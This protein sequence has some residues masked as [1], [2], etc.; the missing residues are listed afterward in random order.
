MSIPDTTIERLVFVRYV[1]RMGVEQ[2][3][4]QEP[5][6]A[7]AILLFHDSADLFLQ[8]AAEHLGASLPV[9]RKKLFIMDFFGAVDALLAK[10]NQRLSERLGI[11]RLTGARNELKHRGLRTAPQDVEGLRASLTNFFAENVPVTF[12]INFD[13]ITMARAVG[14]PEVREQLESAER[15]TAGGDFEGA[16]ERCAVAFAYLMLAYRDVEPEV[17][18]DPLRAG[19]FRWKHPE[20]IEELARWVGELS[21]TIQSLEQRILPLSLGVE[22]AK[23]HRFRFITPAVTV[24]HAGREWIQHSGR[25]PEPTADDAR[26]CYEFV[27]SIALTLQRRFM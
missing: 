11:E 6:S 12:G 10:Q 15:L 18:H 13:E 17:K 16:V 19:S 22:P 14:F 20:E 4:L 9:E 5:A 27:V 24:V 21:S 2:S 8:L 26:F 3:R 25:A 7:V 1:F 23:L